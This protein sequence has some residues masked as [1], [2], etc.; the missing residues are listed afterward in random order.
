MI[1]NYQL[2][3]VVSHLE[4]FEDCSEEDI[5][6]SY[7]DKP[8]DFTVTWDFHSFIEEPYTDN[9]HI[10]AL[11][12]RRHQIEKSLLPLL[13]YFFG[14]HD[15]IFYSEE[16]IGEP[17]HIIQNVSFSANGSLLCHQDLKWNQEQWHQFTT[18]AMFF[19]D[20]LATILVKTQKNLD[21]YCDTQ[22]VKA[23]IALKEK[24]DMD[25]EENNFI[26]PVESFSSNVLPHI[27]KNKI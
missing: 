2:Y 23:R 16:R 9:E 18:D 10:L 15:I 4:Q 8:D 12:D 1:L 24:L 11:R 22:S 13:Q 3:Q 19:E 20:I 27:A 26:S 5:L 7:L 21:N 6:D 25:N 17:V 14:E